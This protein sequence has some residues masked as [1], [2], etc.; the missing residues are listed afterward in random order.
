LPD[1]VPNASKTDRPPTL[2][3]TIHVIILAYFFTGIKPICI[4]YISVLYW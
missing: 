3:T 2:P 4:F 1:V